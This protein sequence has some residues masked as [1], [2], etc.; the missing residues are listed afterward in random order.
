MPPYVDARSRIPTKC[1]LMEDRMLVLLE[2]IHHKNM[3]GGLHFRLLSNKEYKSTDTT[4]VCNFDYR[5]LKTIVIPQLRA[6]G[7]RVS[8]IEI[9]YTD[10]NPY[11]GKPGVYISWNMMP[12]KRW[13]REN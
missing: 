7:F 11:D 2:M 1:L 12:A 10:E 9:V 3:E 13:I 6:I 5:E 8:D 4:K